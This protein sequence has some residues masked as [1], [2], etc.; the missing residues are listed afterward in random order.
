MDFI[1]VVSYSIDGFTD[2][3][4]ALLNLGTFSCIGFMTELKH[5]VGPQH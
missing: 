5:T 2:I 3:F 4:N 1:E